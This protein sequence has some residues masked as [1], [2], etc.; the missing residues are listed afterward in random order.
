VLQGFVD[1]ISRE[2]VQ[3]WAADTDCPDTPVE[4]LV[5]ADGQ[6]LARLRCDQPRADLAR[7]GR[8]GRGD[9]GFALDLQGVLPAG[10]ET[11]L[12]IRFAATGELLPAGEAVLTNEAESAPL[13]PVLVTGLARSGTTL[14]MRRMAA[15]PEICLAEL[16]PFEVRLVS[17]YTTAH[18]VLTAP[19][20]FDASTH[21]DRLEGDGFFVGFNPFHSEH[22][23]PAFREAQLHRELFGG[24]AAA[25]AQDAFRDIIRE[26]YARLAADQGK[27][28]ARYFAEKGNNLDER[29]RRFTRQV[30]P[31]TREIVLF[32]DPRDQLC[33][34]R[35]WFRLS[36]EAAFAMISD[37]CASL[38]RIREER[39]A[40][41]LLLRY[42]DLVAEPAAS[43][44]SLAGFL[45][46]PTRGCA[47]TDAERAMFG[48]HATSASPA[49]SV[50]RWRTELTSEEIDQ[51][52][53][54]WSASLAAFGY[55]AAGSAQAM[56]RPTAGEATGRTALSA[57]PSAA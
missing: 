53:R 38:L 12:S 47:D 23:Q 6:R 17:Y 48:D 22:Y 3:G 13:A 52:D 41:V 49:D 31:E 11:R 32:R 25:R 7:L 50:G 26:Y 46:L 19:G 57:S 20:D 24:F 21:P 16:A 1:H 35:S 9:H 29:T 10:R 43:L 51:C 15:F 30:F 2:R 45:G 5:H 44:T 37:G 54:A 14:L 28:A 36:H 4:I 8:F 27:P 39:A 34:Y 56:P 42:E 18:R 40:S 55:T 33:S